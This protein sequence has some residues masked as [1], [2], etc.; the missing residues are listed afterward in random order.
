MISYLLLVY[1][2]VPQAKGKKRGR[3]EGEEDGSKYKLLCTTAS[4]GLS[5]FE[6]LYGRAVQGPLDELCETREADQW[7]NESVVSHVL[8][9]KEKMSQMIQLARDNLTK[10]QRLQKRWYN[11]TAWEREFHRGDLVLALLLASTN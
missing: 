1:W 10:A 7:S 9:M 6:L 8:S 4:M 2:E 11:W 3:R 5:P